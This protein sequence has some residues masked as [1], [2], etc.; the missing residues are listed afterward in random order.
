M[1]VV[2]RQVGRVASNVALRP[3]WRVPDV[4][5]SEGHTFID[6]GDAELT[7][8]RPHPMIDPSLRNA[9]FV[10]E[11]SDPGVGAVVLDVVLGRGAHPDP[12]A[13]LVPLITRSLERRRGE[14]SVIV[15]V[16]GTEGDPQ[17]VHDQ[18]RRIREAGGLPTR[19]TAHAAA[20][21]LMASGA[22]S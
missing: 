3:E 9:R 20:L 5:A 11:A 14:L 17:R 22:A 16:C 2:S 15:A 7:A 12:A 18:V 8:G 21:A 19:I 6:F 13:D 4:W 1:S 10:H